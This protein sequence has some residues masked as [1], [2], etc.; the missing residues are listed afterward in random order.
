MLV[1]QPR[2]DSNMPALVD[3]AEEDDGD[4]PSI[5]E[6]NGTVAR[7]E[8]AYN[9]NPTDRFFFGPTL[10]QRIPSLVFLLFASALGLLVLS[11]YYSSSNS[12]MFLWV[13][14]GPKRPLAF[15]IFLM[16]VGA[17]V[18]TSLR[19]V[20]VTRDAIE[21]RSLLAFGVPRVRRWNWAQIDRLV[22][23]EKDVLL[24]LWNGTY[25]RLP[26]VRDGKSLVD[27]LERIAAGRGRQVT[28][29]PSKLGA[30]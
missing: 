4:R 16:A 9:P 1:T 15:L 3:P 19:G 17:N 12:A 25:E 7:F 8:M 14:D 22:L 26:A 21:A 30:K 18:Q 6:V 5:T 10:V 27:L 11:A 29:L 28:R 24:E 13:V 23:D 20:V 2:Q